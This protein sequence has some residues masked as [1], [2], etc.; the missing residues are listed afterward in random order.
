M[1]VQGNSPGKLERSRSDE[2][3]ERSSFSESSQLAL[4]GTTVVSL[5]Q[6]ISF[7]RRRISR[8]ISRTHDRLT[9]CNWGEVVNCKL[10][11][12]IYYLYN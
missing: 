10:Y 6:C 2:E 12:S 8:G 5:Y 3:K 11:V 1:G 9:G 7:A 4:R